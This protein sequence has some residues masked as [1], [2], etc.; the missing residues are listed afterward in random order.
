MVRKF[1]LVLAALPFFGLGVYMGCVAVGD[2]VEA[3]LMQRW[4]QAEATVHRAGYRAVRG[5]DAVTYEAYAEY[6]YEFDGVRYTGH[7]IGI[8]G[9]ADNVGDYQRDMARRLKGK[10]ERGEA[11]TVFV[12][13]DKP[14]QAI[15]DRSLRLEM[16]GIETVVSLVFGGAGLAMLIYFL[17]M[18][19]KKDLSDPAY[20]HKP[21]L[22]NVAWQIP[23][24][25]SDS[26]SRMW[27]L[28]VFAGIWNLIAMPLPFLV[29]GVGPGESKI[30]SPIVFLVPLAGIGMI[31]FAIRRTLEWKRFGRALLTL[32]PFPGSIGGQVGGTIDLDLRYDPQ[33]RFSITLSNLYSYARGHGKN[34]SRH[35]M[36][37]WQDTQAAH[38]SQGARGTRLRFCFDVPGN[39]NESDAQP[40]DD[41]YYLWR[42]NLNA[43]LPGVDIDRSYDI[44]VYATAQRSANLS[45]VSIEQ[46]RSVQEQIDI[47][48][49]RKITNLQ[50]KAGGP[51][52]YFPMGR[53][54]WSGLCGTV[55]GS[56]FTLVGIGV[57]VGAGR[58]FFGAVFG[59]IGFFVAVGCF[60]AISNSLEI[61]QQGNDIRSIRRILGIPVIHRRMRRSDFAMFRNKSSAREQSGT[62]H[63]MDYVITAI[64]RRGR[65]IILAEGFTSESMVRTAERVIARAFGLK[66]P[67][68]ADTESAAAEVIDNTNDYLATD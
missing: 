64:D 4:I 62:R 44:P 66:L 49:V 2:I 30:I 36:P 14:S 6:S 26:R 25:K 56:V 15:L 48:A 33:S 21:W 42:L 7:R 3:R 51:S 39:L 53:Y 37:K 13:P 67:R 20:R 12:N 32:D 50:Q 29:F 54:F 24:I 46:A 57:A 19:R 22:A 41:M 1:F 18:P 10:R 23:A 43:D 5:D 63:A 47:A 40:Q 8:Y 59:G 55:I 31:V 68:P 27:F 52:M 58:P 35:E 34:R 9:G 16:V 11:V 38:V 65:K 28:W 17:G 61:F 45:E 60:Y